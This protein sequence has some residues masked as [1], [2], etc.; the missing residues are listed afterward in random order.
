MRI[1]I[2]CFSHD[3]VISA[4]TCLQYVHIQVIWKRRVHVSCCFPP[5]QCTYTVINC[6]APPA[7][8]NC[9]VSVTNNECGDVVI[10]AP[11]DP[12]TIRIFG[13]RTLMCGPDGQWQADVVEG[14]P[15]CIP[16]MLLF[17][18]SSVLTNQLLTGSC[19]KIALL[20]NVCHYMIIEPRTENLRTHVHV[21]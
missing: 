5:H 9:T 16:R 11:L 6:G 18:Y 7:P 10:Y 8:D 17:S 1:T 19:S 20:Y 14:L 4:Q 2:F 21:E 13:D 12:E 3:T 15:F